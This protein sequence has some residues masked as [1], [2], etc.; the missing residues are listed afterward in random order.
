MNSMYIVI[1][2]NLE[3]KGC[4]AC[5]FEGEIPYVSGTVIK[6]ACL[7]ASWLWLIKDYL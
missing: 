5:T 6:D 2:F 7:T 3:W 1:V 4:L